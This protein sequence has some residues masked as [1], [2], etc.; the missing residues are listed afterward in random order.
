MAE[1]RVVTLTCTPSRILTKHGKKTNE[2]HH[3]LALIV[4]FLIP[5][6]HKRQGHTQTSQTLALN[7][8]ILQF[9][10]S[11]WVISCT[12]TAKT[13]LATTLPRYG[14]RSAHAMLSCGKLSR[15]WSPWKLVDQ[16]ARAGG[17]LSQ[18]VRA[19]GRGERT[20]GMY[21]SEWPCTLYCIL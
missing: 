1:P 20:H 15:P 9:H 19:S 7:S 12:R 16:V 21:D 3:F 17:H 5:T 13:Y 18:R 6:V 10:H 11:A 2:H 14:V 8:V 4:H